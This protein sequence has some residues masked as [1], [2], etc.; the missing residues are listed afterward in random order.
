VYIVYYV[1]L[2]KNN[3]T[4]MVVI[5]FLAVIAIN[6]FNDFIACDRIFRHGGTTEYTY[7]LRISRSLIAVIK[8]V[9]IPQL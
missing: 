6:A 1:L 7:E 3:V 9:S 2:K 4:I 8:Q 5:V